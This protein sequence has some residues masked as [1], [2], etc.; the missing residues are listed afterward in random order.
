MPTFMR[1]VPS[2]EVDAVIAVRVG[3]AEIR[4]GRDFDAALL[5]AVVEALGGGAA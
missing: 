3:T 4:V 5:R 2:R 1:V